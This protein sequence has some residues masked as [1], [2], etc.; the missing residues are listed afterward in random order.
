MNDI[1]LWFDCAISLSVDKRLRRDTMIN[2][3]MFDNFR[4]GT[5]VEPQACLHTNFP[6]KYS[7]FTRLLILNALSHDLFKKPKNNRIG[8][9]ETS[10]ETINPS[11]GSNHRLINLNLIFN[12]LWL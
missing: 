7:R 2:I 11:I 1:G 10:E 9:A 5:K 6:F 4:I 8:I 12:K 3:K